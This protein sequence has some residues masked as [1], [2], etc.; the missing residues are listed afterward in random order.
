LTDRLAV[1]TGG[2][3]FI[4][5][6]AVDVLLARGFSV[7]VID[8]LRGGRLANLEHVL[9]RHDF[10]FHE[11]DICAL[12]AGSPTFIGADLVLHF[13]GIGDIVPSVE[14]PLE[15]METNVMGTIR[16]LEAAR[17]SGVRRLV[18]AASS[19]CYGA[20]PDVPTDESSPIVTEYPYALSKYLGEQAAFHWMKVYGLSVNSIRIFNAYGTR[21]RTS[22]AYGA[23]FGVFL[24]Q[25]L[26]GR[27]FTVVGDGTQRRDFVFVT[28]VAEAFVRAGE[29]VTSGQ[30]W[31]VGAGTPE[32]VNHLVEL[33]EGQVTHIP[34]RPGEPEA[35]WAN[36]T[37]IARDLRWAPT[38][39]F[40]QGVATVVANIDY[41]A[42]APLWDQDSIALATEPW[43]RLL[44]NDSGRN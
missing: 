28:D 40:E 16:V 39:P 3:G 31:N 42:E 37:A 6:H 7:R 36:I 8:D 43:F 21:S 29:T 11:A 24:K 32:S 19:S 2:A 22:G 9:E 12:P 35:T 25:K 17:H 23:V 44:A 33:L 41:W 30:V 38:V 10:E 34:A 20:H 18:Y 13:A 1:V 4:G 5:S 26:A 14:R 15:Y 27:P